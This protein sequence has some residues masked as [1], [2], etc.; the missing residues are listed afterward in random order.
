MAATLVFSH[1]H[2]LTIGALLCQLDRRWNSREV[3]SIPHVR[4]DTMSI[5]PKV[6]KS[7]DCILT[8]AWAYL[9]YSMLHVGVGHLFFNL[10]LQLAIGLGL[11]MAH[12]TISVIILYFF[13]VRIYR[14]IHDL[15]FHL[16]RFWRAPWP[17][18][19][20]I[21]DHCLGQVEV[22]TTKNST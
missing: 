17:S 4:L 6:R 16:H 12:G 22:I 1:H 19:A 20:L 18:F 21:A 5:V 13:G 15:K 11:E 10:T 3:P 9:T 7:R 2:H 14:S 8:T